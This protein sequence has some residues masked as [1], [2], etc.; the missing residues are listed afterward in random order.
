M[1]FH[2]ACV[3]VFWKVLLGGEKAARS[4]IH[5]DDAALTDKTKTRYYLAFRK[6]LP[7]FES[8]KS[9][10]DLVTRLYDWIRLMWRSGEPVLTVGDA[11]SAI[12]VFQP[13]TR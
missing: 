10:D 5:L 13:W 6:L 9:Q 8:S 12:H 3:L 2:H 7:F 1:I 4:R 11:R